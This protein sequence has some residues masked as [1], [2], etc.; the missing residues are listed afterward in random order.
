M[1]DFAS[2]GIKIDAKDVTTGVSELDKLTVAGKRAESAV[3]RLGA[4][5]SQAAAK[6]NSASQQAAQL[7]SRM[8]Q[9]SSATRMTGA[10][11]LGLA[12]STNAAAAPA[13]RLTGVVTVLG[14]FLGG[15]FAGLV[16]TATSALV[17]M[18]FASLKASSA[19]DAQ[20][21]AANG[22]IGAMDALNAATTK[23]MATTQSSIRVTINKANAL[24]TQANAARQAAI[25]ELELAK[26]RVAGAKAGAQ[27][28]EPGSEGASLALPFLDRDVKRYEADIAR[29]S[30][31]IIAA[32]GD[33]RFNQ[34]LQI[35]QSVAEK[36]DGATAAAGKYE[37][38]L[39]T[40]NG[41][42]RFN[43]INEKLYR[44]EL[45]KA[46]ATRDR[47]L[48]A[49]K[50]PKKPRKER[51]D[52]SAARLAER[53]AR[54]ALAIDTNIAALSALADAYL[55]SGSAALVAEARANAA[56][57]A[58]KKQGD[59]EAYVA[60]EMRKLVAERTVEGAKLVAGLSAQTSAQKAVND[61]VSAGTM[62]ASDAVQAMQNEAQLRPLIAAQAVAEGKA[63]DALANVI[64]RLRG[65]QAA[66][67]AEAN[68]AKTL[69]A[70]ASGGEELERL[71]LEA[72]L[73]G[74]TNAVRAVALAQL[75]AEQFLRANPGATADE[76]QRYLDTQKDIAQQTADLTTAQDNY[77]AS[78][79]YM[80]DLLVAI[81]EQAQTTASILSSA[82]GGF[83]D[84]IGGVLTAMS[85]MQAR[86]QEIADWRRD[87]LKKA[88]NDAKRKA[89]VEILADKASK[90]AQIAGFGQV[91]GAAK[92]L[93]KEG[94]AGY[95]TL[96][97][98]EKA[99]AIVQAINTVKNIA[100][101]ASK[102]FAMLGPWAFPAVAAMIA[103]M[104]G[105]GFAGGGGGGSA[106]PPTSAEDLQ[107]R[108][109]T[110]TVLGDA[111][112][113]SNSIANSLEIVAAN[114]NRDLEYSNAMLS[115]L[116]S[117]DTSIAKMAGTVARQ[118]Q[119]SGSL[120]D[121]SGLKLG[122]S[123]S[124]GFLGIGKK[125]TTRS[126]YDLGLNLQSGSVSDIIANGI[127]GTTYQVV[128]KVKKKSGFLGIGGGT[129]TSYSTTTGAID[130][131]IT[132]AISDVLMSLRDGLV[133]AADV[134][135]LQGAEAILNSFNVSL[136]KI[137]FKDM[138]GEQIEDQLNAIFSSVG[139]QMAGQLLPSLSALQKVG[140][141]LFE[142]FIRV[143]REY[144][145]VDMALK[146]IGKEF[147]AVGLGSVA[148]R[149]ALV[150]LFDSLEE[151]VERTDFFRTEFLSEAEQMAPIISSVRA[152]MAR[153]GLATVDT[154]DEFKNAVLA[155]DLTTAAGREMYASLLAVAPAFDKTLDY[156]EELNK[157]ASDS[158][159][160]TVDKFGKFAE[161]LRKY[162][163]T[164]FA[165]DA[166][167]GNAYAALRA[168]F[169]Q[170]A[171]LAATGDATA[172]GGLEG[173][174]KDFLSASK[175]NASTLQQYLRDVAMVARGVDAG[176]FAAEETADYAQ[177]QLDALT[178]A[179]TILSQIEAN[180]SG[181]QGFG[182]EPAPVPVVAGAPSSSGT[183]TPV[184][185]PVV[186]QQNQTIIAQNAE[187][188]DLM[189]RQERMWSRFDGD[190]ILIRTDADSPIQTQ[191]V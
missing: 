45:D 108:A 149:D 10:E 188:I 36:Y 150:Q 180:T 122:E 161:S 80:R 175:N 70:T 40:L 87:E 117:I 185:D 77:N 51:E 190:G 1:T 5:A 75:A 59:V 61:A 146:S 85:G 23:E 46:T 35:Q 6:V 132:A 81:D 181:S 64:A 133:A 156:F 60:R 141:G 32:Q 164:L 44:S 72:K 142:T 115:A 65:E 56:G 111:A 92:T 138:T 162:R 114:T 126:L 155:L 82:F 14:G 158:L 165:T 99:F 3:E 110:G 171:G 94:S 191:A 30:G 179:V 42:L 130:G 67:N 167:Q 143:A 17:S 73:I 52:N 163:D 96:E 21:D 16:A 28:G 8:Q 58:I 91:L 101:G 71:K 37:R 137:S 148:A 43:I 95:K 66:S 123:G 152:E 129:K 119:V 55:E 83:G 105:L 27:S 182:N 183:A 106:T 20:K 169:N 7:T 166:V 18:A 124:G 168:R 153:L 29:L 144:Q 98:A 24:I 136:G 160:D 84:A 74:E 131:E 113:K 109:G 57:Q 172:L 25:A 125:S 69:S 76:A 176:I 62:P 49:L 151:F 12:T 31:K 86:E 2:L 147:G 90:N 120:F 48:E 78:L 9:V 178:N 100:A 102:M 145:V 174:G 135:G 89:Q 189:K 38:R 116:R 139:D 34:G 54:D 159:R 140:E 63:K 104:A 41:M 39:E 186:V 33:I 157:T 103:V 187:I 93:F 4:S 19:K 177:L 11:M 26:A 118:I 154:R 121:T 127:A 134:I 22:L 47:E 50:K 15:A 53:L 13:S 97:A 170:T 79:S 107:D 184:V 88:G 112:A 68:R 128:Q 173:A